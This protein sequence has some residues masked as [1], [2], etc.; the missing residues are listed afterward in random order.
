MPGV[1]QGSFDDQ[2]KLNC[3]LKALDIRWQNNDSDYQNTTV[4]GVTK[5]SGVRVS[6]LPYKHICRQLTCEAELRSTFYIWHKGGSRKRRDKIVGAR[7]G[8]TWFLRYK[9][10]AIRNNF[11][12]RQWL[13]SVA[14][15]NV[16]RS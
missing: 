4:F 11:T 2:Q 1:C 10:D 5:S 6:I 12:G 16:T 9:W 14:Y 15:Y 3:G 7:E 8:Q 13:D